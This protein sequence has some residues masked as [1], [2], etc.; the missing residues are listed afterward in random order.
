MN[1]TILLFFLL[2]FAF[3]PACNAEPPV[4]NDITV[5][6]SIY[7]NDGFIREPEQIQTTDE[8]S[9]FTILKNICDANQIDIAYTGSAKDVY[10][11]QCSIRAI[12]FCYRISQWH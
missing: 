3:F 2:I 9:V 1:K 10:K 7:G 5:T 4:G 11:R 6:F 8:T 12:I